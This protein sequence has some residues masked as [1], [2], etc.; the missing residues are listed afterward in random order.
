VINYKVLGPVTAWQ[1]PW[2]ASLLPQHQLLLAILVMERGAPVPRQS[3]ASVLWDD[4]TD[5]PEHA[6]TRVVSE[7]RTQLSA[8]QPTE[9]PLPAQGDTYRLRLTE[10]QADVLRFRSKTYQAGRASGR[11][12]TQLRQEALEEWGGN[13]TGLFG[14]QPLTG[15]RGRWADSKRAELRREYCDARLHC[16]KQ[17]F[18]DHQYDR[19]V[20]ECAQLANEPDALHEEKFVALW[21]I[22]AYRAGGRSEALR[23]YQR[24]MESAQTY[25]GLEPSGFLREIAEI[26]RAEDTS[27]LNGPA[28]LLGLESATHTEG[29]ATQHEST[30]DTAADPSNYVP[31]PAAATDQSSGGKDQPPETGADG[32]AGQAS[33]TGPSRKPG[34]GSGGQSRNGPDRRTVKNKVATIVADKV[35]FGFEAPDH[36]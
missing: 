11:E 19:V 15:L 18:D 30:G 21:M 33:G 34:A 2:T 4:V 27:R 16:L 36:D 8:A 12:A 13:A 35:I 23:I 5:P 26:I 24:A 9:N 14:G 6:L 7:L 22:A 31:T 32:E 25:L 3:L 20:G 29:L 17:E 1:D 10:Q 28:S